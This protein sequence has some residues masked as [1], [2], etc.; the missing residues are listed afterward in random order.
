MGLDSKKDVHLDGSSVGSVSRLH[1]G[2][3]TGMAGRMAERFR[4][5]GAEKFVYGAAFVRR[6]GVDV[7]DP[8]LRLAN[9]GYLGHKAANTRSAPAPQRLYHAI[10]PALTSP[11]VTSPPGTR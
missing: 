1:L 4:E 11:R 9:L 10:A 8:P 5:L 2:G 3:D 6:A 7:R